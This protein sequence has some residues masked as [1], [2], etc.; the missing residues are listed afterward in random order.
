VRAPGGITF[1]QA[2]G[3]FIVYGF[4]TGYRTPQAATWPVEDLVD[5]TKHLA[6]HLRMALGLVAYVREEE[7]NHAKRMNLLWARWSCGLKK[8]AGWG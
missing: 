5:D 3:P 2:D 7:T 8:E 1:A 4:D 6:R